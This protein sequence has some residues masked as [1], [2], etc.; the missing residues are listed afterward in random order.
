MM[1]VISAFLQSIINGDD[2]LSRLLFTLFV[3]FTLSWYV[4]I[5]S[6]SNK[7]TPPLPP[8]PRG[9]PLVG[10]LLSLD[11]ELHSYFAGLAQKH[12]PILK[13]RLGNKLG[14]V[15]TS[16][17][18]ARE[19]LKDH[20]VNFANR[21]VPA[22]A[23]ALAYDGSDIVWTPYGPEWRMLRKVCVL[24]MLSNATLDSVYTLRR[25]QVRE[26]VAYFYSRVGSPVNI[27]E[28]M[29]LTVLKVITNMLWGG[30][31]EGEKSASLGS[32]FREVVSEMT[33]HLGKPNISDFYPSLARFDLQGIV[34]KMARL[35]RRFDRIFDV[36]I[37]QRLKINKEDGSRS[38][39][40]DILSGKESED[41]LQFL[42]KLKDEGDSKTPLTMLHLK[43]LLMDMVVGGTDTSSNTIEFAMAE[44]MSK[45]EVMNKAQQELADVVGKENIVEES[46]IHKLTYLHAVMKE[47]LRLHPVLPLLVPHCPSETCTVGG[48]TIPKGSRVFVNV[49][50]IQRD[51]AIWENPLE[52]DPQRFF[53]SSKWDYTGSDFNYFPFGSGRRICAGTA[54]AERMVMYS[55]AT[56]LHS[57]DWKLPPGDQKLDLSE[58]CGI[59]LKKKNP[60]FAIPTPRLPDP[61]L[62]T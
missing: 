21:D 51:P 35:A 42:L 55:L 33:E 61:S 18:L 37:D 50:A 46:H 40:E 3:I 39:A 27:G 60:L 29:F 54:M 15:V 2:P 52:F 19:V 59:V 53:N 23:R 49:W 20:D 28:Q 25:K 45:P 10:N 22:A 13:L 24:K 17:S 58:K 16:P 43:A 56:L 31:V 1:T 44:I 38:A 8:G 48:Y 47:T 6:K 4:W 7:V 12:G 32:E 5:Y 41:F 36:M 30:T 9:L 57:F 26:T 11:P 14:I 62:Y 34:G